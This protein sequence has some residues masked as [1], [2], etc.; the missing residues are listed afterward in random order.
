M[1]VDANRDDFWH[2][3]RGDRCDVP[4]T[5]TNTVGRLSF[6]CWNLSDVVQTGTVRVVEG[7]LACD[8]LEKPLVIPPRGKLTFTG[9]VRCEQVGADAPTKFALVGTFNGKKTT[10][11]AFAFGK[12]CDK[13]TK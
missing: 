4:L 8:S 12:K 1:R 11:L 13:E 9:M 5:L 2:Q 3:T 6:E 10:P 7:P